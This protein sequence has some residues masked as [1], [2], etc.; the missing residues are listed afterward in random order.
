MAKIPVLMMRMARMTVNAYIHFLEEGDDGCS[1]VGLFSFTVGKEYPVYKNLLR[2]V[3]LLNGY[4]E[5]EFS[6]HN[7]Y[8]NCSRY[9]M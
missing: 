4:F 3:T 8:Q 7:A 5:Y 6:F 1:V 9:F 2:I